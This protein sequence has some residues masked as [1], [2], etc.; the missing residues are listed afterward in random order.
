METKK[1]F[2]CGR[3]LPIE[4]FYRH[5]GMKDGHLN[6]CKECTKNDVH[7][8]YL[9]NIEKPEYVENER[10][11]GR[12][13]YRRLGYKTRLVQ[14]CEGSSTREYLE[15]RSICM[16][17]CEVHHWNYNR[18]HDVFILGRREHKFIHQFLVF[19]NKSKKFS[20]NNVLLDTKDKHREFLREVLK[21]RIDN[22]PE[23]DFD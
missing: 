20:H 17:G 16:T 15:R 19:D 22:I 21:E 8:K 7:K 2:K 14:H 10:K 3:I 6:K 18:P 23:Y 13:K 1:C 4:D 9:E 5:G 12:D 11:R